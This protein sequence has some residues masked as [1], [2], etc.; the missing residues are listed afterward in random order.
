MYQIY[1]TKTRV[2]YIQLRSC[3]SSELKLILISASAG[4]HIIKV[5]I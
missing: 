5:S 3:K 4:I 1:M 2:E